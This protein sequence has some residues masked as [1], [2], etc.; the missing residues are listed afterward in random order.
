LPTALRHRRQ[1]LAAVV[2]LVWGAVWARAFQLQVIDRDDLAVTADRQS[3]RQIRI[4]APRGEILDR[5]GRLLAANIERRSFFA[6]P[7]RETPAQVLAAKFAKVRGVSSRRLTHKLRERRDRFTWMARRCDEKTA[8]RVMGWNLQG[9]FPTW[10][11]DRA[12]PASLSGV[13]DPLGFVNAD[14]VGAA[15]LES[16]YEPVL[17]GTDG[18]GVFL[19]DAVGRRFSIDPVA[20]QKPLPGRHLRLTLDVDWQSILAE[21]LTEAVS[22]WQAN[23]GLALLMDPYTGAIIA[24]A[25]SRPH[26]LGRRTQKCRLVSDVLEPGSTFKIISFA[27]AFSDGVVHPGEYFDGGDGV[28][29]FS[30]RTIRDDKKHAVISAAEAFS[31]SSN[32]VTGQIANR[33]DPGRLDFWVRRFG[34]GDKTGIDLPGESSGRIAVQRQSE[35]NIATRAIGHGVAVTP[36]QLAVAGAAIANGGYLVRP[37]LVAA[38]QSADGGWDET[39]ISGK[40]ILQPE[41]ACLLRSLMQSVVKDGTASPISDPDYPIAGKTGTAEKPDPHTGRYNKSKFIASFIGFYPA[42]CPRLL[43]LVILDEPEPVHYGGYTAAP[44]LLNTIRRAT[45]GDRMPWD[46]QMRHWTSVPRTPPNWSRQLI[47]AVAPW[48]SA[49]DAYAAT[50]PEYGVIGAEESHEPEGP[51][52]CVTGWDRICG[53]AVTSVYDTTDSS[54]SCWPDL[55]GLSLR[56]ALAVLRACEADARVNGSGIVVVQF[57]EARSPMGDDRECRLTLR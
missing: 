17:S 54:A 25:D 29:V 33:L 23:W 43:G 36:L 2:L 21:E 34:F 8:A 31:L 48:I 53:A 10:E 4:T 1:L 18:R 30:G 19:A 11:Y 50:Q 28:G 47:G 20:G 40:R 56:D 16:Y 37:H 13:A 46:G 7:D 14:L 5:E 15:G 38:V 44:V 35:Y 55:T 3:D 39:P 32:V 49:T 9:V 12:Y 27:A 51:S 42:R 6:Y 24:M 57:P 22:K 45:S 41:V 26:G 52:S